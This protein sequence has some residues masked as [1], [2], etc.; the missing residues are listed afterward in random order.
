MGRFL[1]RLRFWRRAASPPLRLRVERERTA[2]G[3][4][5]DSLQNDLQDRVPAKALHDVLVALDELL[6]NVIMHA[7]Q[8]AGPIDVEVQRS[9]RELELRIGYLADEFDPTAWRAAHSGMT[10]AASRIGGLGIHL[11]RTLMDDFRY[12]YVDGRNLLTLVKRC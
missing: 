12:E 2:I 7:E 4:C 9:Q 8:A 10:I 3:R 6:T 1:D 11:V 5:S